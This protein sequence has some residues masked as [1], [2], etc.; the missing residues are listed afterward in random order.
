VILASDQRADSMAYSGIPYATEQGI[1]KRVSG[2]FSRQTGKCKHFRNFY[3]RSLDHY[4]CG[5]AVAGA[6]LAN[7][8]ALIPRTR[9][10]GITAFMI[11]LIRPGMMIGRF[12]VKA[13]NPS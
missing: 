8:L 1:F 3:G 13:R 5:A 10:A 2:N 7:I 6:L 9:A 4:D 11:R 12:L